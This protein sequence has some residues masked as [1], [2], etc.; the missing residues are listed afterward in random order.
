[1]AMTI[2]GAQDLPIPGGLNRADPID[3]GAVD[4]QVDANATRSGSSL[5]GPASGVVTWRGLYVLD[6][7]ITIEL[8][9]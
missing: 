4:V 3:G 7:E 8:A 9:R 5:C 1:M 6:T 2:V